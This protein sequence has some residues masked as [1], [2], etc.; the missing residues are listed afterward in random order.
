MDKKI[1]QTLQILEECAS[2][3][4]LVNY[5][6]LYEQIKLNRENPS[7]RNKGAK[8]LAEVNHIT[9]KKNKTMLSAIVTLKGDESP[10][11]GF[12]EFATELKL[13]KKSA[14]ENDKLLFWAEE[15]KKV[16]KEYG[17]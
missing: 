17:E 13:L 16:F 7:D 8:I 10:A 4:K 9:M 3:K 1:Q 2:E 11:Y 15:I 5:N 14:N 12:Y 6:V